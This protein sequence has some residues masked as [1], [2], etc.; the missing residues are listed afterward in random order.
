[1][2][3]TR[4]DYESYN[5]N[6]N[7]VTH[8]AIQSEGRPPYVW[9]TYSVRHE[10]D[11]PRL[12]SDLAVMSIDVAKRLFDFNFKPSKYYLTNLAKPSRCT[13]KY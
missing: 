11:L 6:R 10:A 9:C 1:M 2:V 12:P 8:V 13:D 7:G 3:K 5:P 4:I